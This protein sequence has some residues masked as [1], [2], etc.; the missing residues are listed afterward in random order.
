MLKN[1]IQMIQS[2]AVLK[3]RWKG[4]T[5]DLAEKQQDYVEYERELMKE[6]ERGEM[7]LTSVVTY[8]R[9]TQYMDSINEAVRNILGELTEEPLIQKPVGI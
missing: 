8:Y 1:C 5:V 2:N 3:G 7:K 6:L 9:M 4:L